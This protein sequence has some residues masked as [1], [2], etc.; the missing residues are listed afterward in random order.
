MWENRWA[1]A[2]SDAVGR[3]GGYLLDYDRVPRQIA[4]RALATLAQ[5][6]SM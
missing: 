5:E 6:A 3:V 4:E 1:A 2:F